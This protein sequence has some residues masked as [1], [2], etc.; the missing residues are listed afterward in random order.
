M[1]FLRDKRQDIIDYIDNKVSSFIEMKKWDKIKMRD[2]IDWIRNFGTTEEKWLAFALLN[3][4]IYY[5]EAEIIALCKRLMNLFKRELMVDY[6]IKNQKLPINKELYEYFSKIEEETIYTYIT[7][8]D[9]NPCDSGYLMCRHYRSCGIPE[10]K[11]TFHNNIFKKIMDGANY[12]VFID[13]LIGTGSQAVN[14]WVSENYKTHFGNSLQEIS[15]EFPSVKFYYL[16]LV[17]TKNGIEHLR[18]CIPNLKVIVAETYDESHSVFSSSSLL[19]DSDEE[20]E[21]YILCFNEVCERIGI[22]ENERKG[23]GNLELSLAFAHGIPDNS[24][25]IFRYGENGWNPLMRRFGN[26]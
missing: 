15:E 26:G 7:G 14:F 20:K 5:S 21:R 16:A 2:K 23:I 11:I 25:P 19:W 13:D 17:G 1:N 22:M 6:F 18:T 8:E 9:P 24:L 12:I 3:K 10:S 4:F